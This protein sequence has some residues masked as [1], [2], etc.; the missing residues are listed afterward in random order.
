MTGMFIV[1]E[2]GE[3]SGKSGKSK[4][5]VE[6][7]VSE[8]IDA[9]WTREP[10]GSPYAE[11]IRAVILDQSHGKHADAETLFGLFWAARRDHL[12]KTVIPAIERGAIVISDRFDGSTYAYQ[13]VGQ[14][15]AQLK[16][17]F[18]VM[19]EHYVGKYAPQHYIFCD[20][21]PSIGIARAK[22]RVEQTT[23]FDEREIEFHERVREGY[24]EFFSTGRI[25]HTIMD[26]SLPFEEAKQKSLELVR[27]L[28]H[29]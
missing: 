19:R 26:A 7:L 16:K 3:G 4:F 17:L 27:R 22:G 28:A 18:W 23:H 2:G 8:G 11:I 24:W 15:Q 21:E 20:L 5:V 1:F 12:L 25:P 14:E 29:V 9:L 13:I 10:G 6:N